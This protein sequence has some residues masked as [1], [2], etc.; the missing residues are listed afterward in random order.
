MG[1]RRGRP[2]R[3]G[4]IDFSQTAPQRCS[5]PIKEEQRGAGKRG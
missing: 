1:V 4:V 3:M 2:W 5:L